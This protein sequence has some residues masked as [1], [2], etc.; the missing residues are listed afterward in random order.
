MGFHAAVSGIAQ[1]VNQFQDDDLRRQQQRQAI[2]QGAMQIQEMQ[3]KLDMGKKALAAKA[4][5]AGFYG[6]PGADMGG[7]GQQPPAAQGGG[8]AGGSQTPAGNPPPMPQPP[9]PGQ[10]S[11]P[12]APPQAAPP[13]RPPMQ[14]PQG[15]GFPPPQAIMQALPGARISSGQRS[16]AQNADVGGVPNSYHLSGQAYD[17]VPPPG[18]KSAQLAAVARQKFPGLRVLDEGTH[19]HI[20]PDHPNAPGAKPPMAAQ[21]APGGPGAAPE[22]L[23]PPQPQQQAQ[24]PQGPDFSPEGMVRMKHAIFEKVAKANPNANPET[25]LDATNSVV[26]GLSKIA[27]L[28]KPQAQVVA[29]QAREAG[30]NERAQLGADTRKEVAA[31]NNATS[32][33][34]TDKRVTAQKE[35]QALAHED[36]GKSLA[37]KAAGVGG[38]GASPAQQ[39]ALDKLK[40]EPGIQL[41]AEVFRRTGKMPSMGYGASTNSRRQAVMELAGEGAAKDQ[42]GIAGAPG[43]QASF[44]ADS[45]ALADQAKYRARVSSFE[46]TANKEADLALQL[47]GKGAGTAAGPVLNRWIQG[48]RAA[49]GNPDVT[50]FDTAI[51]SL[52]GEYAKIMAGSTGAAGATDSARAEA[53]RLLNKNLSPAQLRANIATMRKGMKNRIDSLNDEEGSIKKRLGGGQPAPAAASTGGWSVV[54]VQ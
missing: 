22:G 26:E 35:G 27:A 11:Q 33:A 49:T 25:I 29:L 15:G 48:G 36:R 52:K 16:A 39:Q 8:A 9:M 53:D 13:P 17:V 3:S 20:Q 54:K 34:N 23:A 5:E 43:S 42:G 46:E 47:M 51:T 1:G 28:Q 4:A 21:A 18:V 37:L 40:K 41:A 2:Q 31:G 38:A 50:A 14:A 24:A 7:G 6:S 10:S 30:Q 12:M 45:G 19:I 32:T 44:K